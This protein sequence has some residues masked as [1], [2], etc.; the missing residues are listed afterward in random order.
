MA[1]GCIVTLVSQPLKVASALTLARVAWQKISG[2]KDN[3]SFATRVTCIAYLSGCLAY[4]KVGLLESLERRFSTY[5]V[6]NFFVQGRLQLP[7]LAS[8]LA[9]AEHSRVL[10][11]FMVRFLSLCTMYYVGSTQLSA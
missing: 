8:R 2:R 5:P 4:L 10:L 6:N 1:L 9:G 11:A 7:S 3:A